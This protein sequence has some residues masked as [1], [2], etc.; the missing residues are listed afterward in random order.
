MK[1]RSSHAVRTSTTNND[2]SDTTHHRLPAHFHATLLALISAITIGSHYST[3][4][5]SSLGPEIIHFLEIKRSQYGFLYSSEEIPG[6]ILPVVGGVA[7]TYIPHGPA[8]VVLS[9]LILVS[10][11]LCAMAVTDKSYTALF[12]GRFFFG[13]FDGALT[14]LQGALVAHWF[15]RRISSSFGVTLLVSRASSFLGLALP[16]YLSQSFGLVASMWF[17]VFL[18]VPAFLASILYTVLSARYAQALADNGSVESEPLLQSSTPVTESRVHRRGYR[19]FLGLI[20]S[21][22]VTFWLICYLWV[23]VAGTV[24]SVAHFAPDAFSSHFGI[25]SSISGLLSAS[26]IIV[27]GLGSPVFGALQDRTGRRARI[28]S[29]A[30]VAICLGILACADTIGSNVIPLPKKFKVFFGL[31]LV[32]LGFAS[33][34]VTLMS[35]LAL[36][37]DDF[38]TAAALGL[39][40]A[41]ENAGLAVLHVVT[42][43]LR[44][45]F[46]NYVMSF[47][48]LSSLAASGALVAFLLGKWSPVLRLSSKEMAA[49]E[50]R[51]EGRTLDD[52]GS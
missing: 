4:S 28:L 7:L 9:G 14:T 1:I 17:S 37:V 5:L 36:S 34:P 12:L 51:D 11:S 49:L 40:K 45:D 8:A 50:S 24:F 19:G 48:A 47:L 13:L 38:V 3:H 25:T 2:F 16:A 26:M 32:A 20:R 22:S 33:A 46:G 30:C 21:F 23:V 41:S 39:Y 35:S 52:E 29:Y 43:L 42:G 27:G 18:C 15:R 10:T 44:D 6:I 31:C